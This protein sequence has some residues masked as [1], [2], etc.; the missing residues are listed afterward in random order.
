MGNSFG[1]HS[2]ETIYLTSFEFDAMIKK[3]VTEGV[4][5]ALLSLVTGG[6]IGAWL[7]SALGIQ[8]NPGEF[9]EG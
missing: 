7:P 3:H 1:A 5:F 8:A 4:I 2:G 6:L 9:R